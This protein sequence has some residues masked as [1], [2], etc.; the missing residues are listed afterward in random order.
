MKTPAPFPGLLIALAWCCTWPAPAAA[1][2]ALHPENPR[3]FLYRGKPT[4]VITSGEHYGAVLNLDFDYRRYL[5]TLAQNQLNGTRTWVGAYAETG[6]N[7]NI[8]G[9]TLDPAPGRFVCPWARSEQPGYADGGNKFDLTRWDPAYFA[10][11][12][13]F[14]AHAARRRIIVEI[15]LFC[16]MYED[17]MWSVCPLNPR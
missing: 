3:Y 12:R 14:V 2:L 11:L 13:D 4:V 6:G 17:S 8:A 16:P 9:N 15:N 10:R 7:F 5:D 1:P